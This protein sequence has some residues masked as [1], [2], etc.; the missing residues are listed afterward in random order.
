MKTSLTSVVITSGGGRLGLSSRAAGPAGPA[1]LDALFFFLV[2]EPVQRLWVR[3]VDEEHAVQVVH[4]VL[5]DACEPFLRFDPHLLSVAVQAAHQHL[6]R[7][8]H[9]SLE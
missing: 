1:V 3:A 6:L 4:F 5:E 8:R 9:L 7:S 2:R